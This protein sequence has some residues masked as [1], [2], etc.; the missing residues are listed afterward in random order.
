M[1]SISIDHAL[2]E[3]ATGILV[4]EGDFGWSDVGAWSAL[5]GI[6]ERDR[7][8]NAIRGETVSLDATG[9][10]V[11]N[12]GRMTAL[13]GVR[14]LVVVEAGDALLVCAADQDQRVREIVDILA[15]AGKKK[16]L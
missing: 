5:L 15:K 1:P 13:V 14:D 9:C 3:R 7:A 6:W 12:P 2:M 4:G 8:G 11:Y 10:L 16:Y